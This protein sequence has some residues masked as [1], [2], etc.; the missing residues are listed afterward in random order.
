MHLIKYTPR[1]LL[2][3]LV[4]MNFSVSSACLGKAEGFSELGK[5]LIKVCLFAP[6]EPPGGTFE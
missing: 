1:V 6:V 5:F 4:L 3:F 2:H